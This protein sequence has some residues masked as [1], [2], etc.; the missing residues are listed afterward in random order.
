MLDLET[1]STSKD[2]AIVS[3]GAVRFNK[4]TGELGEAFYQL[5]NLK[6]AQRAGGRI[7]GDTVIWWLS[8]REEARKALIGDESVLIET[9]LKQ[10]S[11]WM[12]KYPVGELWANGP[13]FDNT[14]LEAAYN[15]LG[16]T[17]PWS[18]KINRCYRTIA[19]QHPEVSR[20]IIQGEVEH[21]ALA[22]ALIQA[23][24]LCA[25]FG[26]IK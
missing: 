3:I 15:R 26:E 5:V 6:S 4:L 23:R 25:I 17:P 13:D 16:W 12:R 1:M 11:E 2:A 7:D 9:A 21:N 22:D 8:Q 18:Y 20:I 19:A 14:I 24:H 10:F